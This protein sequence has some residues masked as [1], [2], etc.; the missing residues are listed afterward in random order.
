MLDLGLSKITYRDL[1][2]HLLDNQEKYLDR[3]KPV[4]IGKLLADKA[5]QIAHLYLVGTNQA[6]TVT[7]RNKD[8]IHSCEIIKLW[9]EKHHKIPTTI[10]PLGRDGTNPSNFED[11]FQWWRNIW[12]TEITPPTEQEIWLCLKGGVGQASEAG[13]ISGLSVH[14]NQIKFF[15]FHPHERNNQDG[16]PSEYSGPF[17]GSNYLWDRTQQ[18]ALTLLRRSDY[19]GAQELL[20]SYI[21]NKTIG[22]ATPNLIKAGVAWN[23]GQFESFLQLAKSSMSK[24]I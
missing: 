19:A 11:M 23:Q 21:D 5:A 13:R 16:H 6:N 22:G 7:Q 24:R 1:T 4:I 9:V 18:Q 3:L 20:K 14:A 10:I 15:D 8:T 2:K 12:R 17:I